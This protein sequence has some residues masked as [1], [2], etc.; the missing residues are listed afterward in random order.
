MTFPEDWPPGCP[1]AEATPVSEAVVRV[2]KTNPPSEKDFLSFIELGRHPSGAT[3]CPCM[4][5]GL[6]VFLDAEDARWMCLKYPRL[7]RFL[8]RVVLAD[9]DGVLMPTNGP[10]TRPGGLRSGASG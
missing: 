8:A 3:A 1:P 7:R 6:S 9:G 5:W 10:P 2:V 4:P